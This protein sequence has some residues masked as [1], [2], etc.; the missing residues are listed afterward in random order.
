MRCTRDLLTKSSYLHYPTARFYSG[1]WC[2]LMF[3][4]ATNKSGNIF[5]AS[6]E[7]FVSCSWT[8]INIRLWKNG[9]PPIVNRCFQRLYRRHLA[10]QADEVAVKWLYWSCSF[11]WG[12]L[13]V[14]YYWVI[15]IPCTLHDLDCGNMPKLRCHGDSP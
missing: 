6:R 1:A 9:T 7:I 2:W 4:S 3:E 13:K 12:S 15:S 11:I 8:H 10:K 14:V 5:T